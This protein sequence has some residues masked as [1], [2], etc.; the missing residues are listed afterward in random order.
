MRYN[1]IDPRFWT[2]R[3]V[4][5]WSD[6]AKLLALYLLSSPHRTT[7]GLFRLPKAYIQADLEWSPERLGQPFRQLLESRFLDYDDDAQVV[8]I[9]NALKYQPLQNANQVTGALR[10]LEEL[11]PTRLTCDFQQLA[12]QF[13]QRLAKRLPEG[14]GKPSPTSPPSAPPLTPT[15]ALTPEGSKTSVAQARPVS[16]DT[17]QVFEAWQQATGKHRARLDDKRARLIRAALKAFPLTDVLDAVQGW[18]HDPWPERSRHNGLE[19]L[20]RDAAH[21]EKFRDLCRDGPPP[22]ALGKHSQ[23]IADTYQ[24]MVAMGQQMGQ[25]TEQIDAFDD[26]ERVDPD[27]RQTQ[28]QLPRPSHR[29]RYGT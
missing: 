11:P 16:V 25:Q 7:E 8:L 14:F 17:R 9:R 1:R 3:A 5:G 24:A 23:Q 28:R 20:L 13:C 29:T 15:P 19:V 10:L 26:V 22:P 4:R 18:R 12:E 6:D 2:D 27:R 21:I